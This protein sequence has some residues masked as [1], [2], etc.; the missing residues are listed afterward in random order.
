[1]SS[2]LEFDGLVNLPPPLPRLLPTNFHSSPTL[3]PIDSFKSGP[4]L[5]LPLLLPRTVLSSP[6]SLSTVVYPPLPSLPF[7]PTPRPSPRSIP[8]LVQSPSLPFPFLSL[9]HLPRKR[10]R[11]TL[12][13]QSSPSKLSRRS[14]RPDRKERQAFQK[15]CSEKD[16]MGK[17]LFAEVVS[18]PSLKLS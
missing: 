5:Q 12:P 3:P 14:L 8:Q 13:I 16:K 10:E 6:V 1:M 9:P 4:S 7:P 11:R 17:L 2:L 15:S 18:N